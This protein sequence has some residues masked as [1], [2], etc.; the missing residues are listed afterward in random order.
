[1]LTAIT[2]KAIARKAEKQRGGKGTS[3]SDKDNLGNFRTASTTRERRRPLLDSS[4]PLLASWYKENNIY[5]TAM[6]I[7]LYCYGDT[8]VM[9]L[10]HTVPS[11]TRHVLLQVTCKRWMAETEGSQV[12]ANK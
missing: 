12:V 1:V 3:N 5:K 7:A 4:S 9:I 2:S 10:V 11:S 8:L 6:L